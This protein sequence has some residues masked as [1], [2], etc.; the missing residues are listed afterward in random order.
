MTCL[1]CGSGKTGI[2]IKGTVDFNKILDIQYKITEAN[3]GVY[4]DIYRCKEC[5]FYFVDR[6]SGTNKFNEYYSTQPLDKFYIKD[7]AGRRKAF[8]RI[9]SKIKSLKPDFKKVLDIGCG[10]GFFLAEMDKEGA[11]VSG[12]EVS[13]ESVDFAKKVL[14]LPNIF[15]GS[16]VDI[17]RLFRDSFFDVIT[18]LDVIEH[19][20][21]TKSVF[22]NAG[23]KLKKG[24]LLVITIPIIDS[25][26]AKISGRYWH[27]L[28]PSH[29]NYF[30]F[31][32]LEKMSGVLGYR[33]LAKRW[34]RKYLTISYLIRRLVK[35]NNL[36]LPKIFDI[37][38][39]FNLFDE[40]EIYF[41]KI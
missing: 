31:R 11:D 29:I 9:I 17:D 22:R 14:N 8:S 27:A 2:Y 39:P 32:S 18:A 10:P 16:D 30:T 4:G 35:K 3:S 37:I 41:E 12:L 1:N 34:H 5:D 25:I 28:V 7:E 19:V 6:I 24:G 36:P 13:G 20:Q 40:A 21:D 33:L 23:K 15:Q 26:S 38:I